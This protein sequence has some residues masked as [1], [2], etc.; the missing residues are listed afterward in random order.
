MNEAQ[1]N[2]LEFHELFNI[3]ISLTPTVPLDEDNIYLRVDLADEEL[4]ELT[5]AMANGDLIEI[6]DALGDLITVL[7]GTAIT[8][9][10]DMDPIMKEIH[11]SNMTKGD[12]EIVRAPNGKILKGEN[13]SPPDLRAII[14]P[15]SGGR[16]KKLKRRRTVEEVEEKIATFY[17]A[18]RETPDMTDKHR[19]NCD[20]MIQILGWFIGGGSQ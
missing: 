14:F 16:Q 7:H 19:E 5:E 20:T 13:W 12:P 15:G 17:R 6:A 11:R 1:E 9:G 2:V 4:D 10:L 3:P 18:K 8:Y